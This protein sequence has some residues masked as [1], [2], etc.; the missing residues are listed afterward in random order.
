MKEIMYVLDKHNQTI[1]DEDMPILD[2]IFRSLPG[3]RIVI[4]NKDYI[5]FCADTKA[6]EAIAFLCDFDIL[7]VRKGTINNM[8]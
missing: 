4:E 5:Q 2:Y 6:M 8:K 7:A 3:V 1:T